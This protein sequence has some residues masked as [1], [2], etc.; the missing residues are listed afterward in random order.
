MV[1]LGGYGPRSETSPRD[2]SRPWTGRRQSGGG[3][4]RYT[5]TWTLHCPYEELPSFDSVRLSLCLSFPPHPS[6][7][8]ETRSPEPDR[9]GTSQFSRKDLESRQNSYLPTPSESSGRTHLDGG[10]LQ[11]HSSHGKYFSRRPMS[12]VLVRTSCS[13]DMEP[14]KD[15]LRLRLC[16][17]GDPK[18]SLW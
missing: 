16:R 13:G 12:S 6:P 9:D 5:L 11:C 15:G 17:P 2:V 7:C 10:S 1:P 8:L 14:F 3:V 4:L 18:M